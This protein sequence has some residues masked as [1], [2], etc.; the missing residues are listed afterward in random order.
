[1][2]KDPEHAD[3]YCA[4]DWSHWEKG[5]WIKSWKSIN[6]SAWYQD[7]KIN[8]LAR[9]AI[10]EK[11]YLVKLAKELPIEKVQTMSPAALMK[12]RDMNGLYAINVFSDTPGDTEARA[13]EYK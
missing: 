8:E 2:Y 7:G 5:R 1:M 13:E 6:S 9:M 10:L 12:F 4:V 11:F 3:N